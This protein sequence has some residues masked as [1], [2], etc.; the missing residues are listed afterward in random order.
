MRYPKVPEF[1]ITMAGD[2]VPGGDL[3]ENLGF[4]QRTLPPNGWFIME[5]P[6]KYMNDLEV[7]PILGHLH[8]VVGLFCGEKLFMT[9]NSGDR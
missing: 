6:M 7:A 5:K 8:F 1:L 3:V 9:G 2:E 4:P